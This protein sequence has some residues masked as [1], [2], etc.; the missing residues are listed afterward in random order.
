MLM[1]FLQSSCIVVT[2]PKPIGQRLFSGAGEQV[3]VF[4]RVHVSDSEVIIFLQPVLLNIS[5]FGSKSSPLQNK[6]GECGSGL[7]FS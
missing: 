6:G 7:S 4:A 2:V 5:F 3:F 1:D